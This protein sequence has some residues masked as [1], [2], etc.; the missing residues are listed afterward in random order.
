MHYI[1][2]SARM[3]HMGCVGGGNQEKL[4]TKLPAR[5]MPLLQTN[6]S[7]WKFTSKIFWLI[8]IFF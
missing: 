4:N 5:M 2:D 6:Y 7:F 3:E 8:R 1:H